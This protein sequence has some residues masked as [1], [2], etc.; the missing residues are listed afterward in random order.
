[1][2]IKQLK[3]ADRDSYEGLCHRV[4]ADNFL[5]P[6][7]KP[8]KPALRKR[9]LAERLE[10]SVG[11][12]YLPENE[13]QNHYF[14]TCLPQQFDEYIWFDETRAVEPLSPEGGVGLFF[15]GGLGANRP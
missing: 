5:L 13:L 10:R 9:L 12:I 4:A 2:E 15:A 8:I 6:L 11:A 3:S 14:Y 7:S 1:M